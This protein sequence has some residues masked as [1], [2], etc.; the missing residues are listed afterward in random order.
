[1]SS[2][3]PIAKRLRRC[4]PSDPS[5]RG[6]PPQ[7]D[8][9]NFSWPL[10]LSYSH[11]ARYVR[12][13]HSVPCSSDKKSRMYKRTS[14]L[15]HIHIRPRSILPSIRRRMQNYSSR[16]TRLCSL[17]HLDAT[18]ASNGTGQPRPRV[19]T[20]H[21]REK[22]MICSSNGL[23]PIWFASLN[24]QVRTCSS[25]G[26]EKH[27]LILSEC[28]QNSSGHLD[29][30]CRWGESYG[31]FWYEHLLTWTHR[32]RRCSS[33]YSLPGKTPGFRDVATALV[34][35]IET[36]GAGIRQSNE[37]ESRLRDVERI[38][39][40]EIEEVRARLSAVNDI[41]IYE[42]RSML[43]T[44]IRQVLGRAHIT[45]EASSWS[46]AQKRAVASKLL[47][48]TLKTRLQS[49]T[50]ALCEYSY[51][52]LDT[53]TVILIECAPHVPRPHRATSLPHHCAPGGAVPPGQHGPGPAEAAELHAAVEPYHPAAFAGPRV[54]CWFTATVSVGIG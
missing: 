20:I 29:G 27:T 26:A 12:L 6:L 37:V 30:H 48:E 38:P 32:R 13:V 11:R 2:C 34:L 7:S 45:Q 5:R 31:L 46:F 14:S 24:L 21:Q 25:V 33:V 40:D 36:L 22:H 44:L 8:L 51:H 17:L 10:R 9:F 15:I 53:S 23:Q 35:D 49:A 50:D 52:L 47:A 39:P 16:S 28:R 41:W 1:M 42:Y 19:S 4:W 3:S 18:V 54:R 43:I